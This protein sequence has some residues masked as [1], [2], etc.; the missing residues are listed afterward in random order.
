LCA[1]ITLYAPLKK[2][3]VRGDKKLN[4]GVVGI[5][6]LGTMGIKIAAALGHNV[7]AISRSAHK[8][9]LAQEKG[10]KGFINSSDP[11]SMAKGAASLHL[12]VNTVSAPHQLKD[13]LPL[14]KSKGTLVQLGLV[15]EPHTFS[16]LDI[17]FSN[18]TITASM[19]G[20]IAD[21]QELLELCAEHN[22]APDVQHIEAN[23]IDWAYDQLLA[24]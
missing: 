15:T 22:I 8:E 21:T 20:G 18:K 14:L 7:T 6:G 16:Q 2:F 9:K 3:G 12:I 17:L 4:I 19:I 24:G 23:Q 13:L 1:G 5:G 10:A 11:E